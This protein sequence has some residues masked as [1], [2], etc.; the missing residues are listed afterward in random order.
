[1]INPEANRLPVIIT[2]ST[3]CVCLGVV[4]Y[5]VPRPAVIVALAFVPLAG[6]FVLNKTFWLVLLFVVFSFF[7]IHEA[8]PQLYSLKI[9]LMLSI[10]A[11][12]ALLWHA[13]ISKELKIFWH[14]CLN[15]LAIFWVLVFI[16][17]T[18]ASNRPIA[19]AEFKGV[20]WKIIVMTLAIVWLVNSAEYLV[21]TSTAI[22][23]AGS[24]VAGIAINNSIHGIGLVEG[25]R[26]TI[27]R[28]FGSMLGD[29]NDL[30]LVLM[31]PLAFA[32]SQVVTTGIP[33]SKRIISVGVT[34]LLL[35]AVIATQSRGGLLGSLAV[36]GIFAF[37]VIRSKL[38][39]I[40]LG[41][42]GSIGLYFVAGIS[43]R[44]S[45]GAAEQGVDES[46]MGRIYAWEAAFKMA[47]DNPLTGVGLDNF[48]S[49]YFFYSSHW[50]GLNHAVHS[51]WFGVLA[52]TG[53]LGL[54]IFLILITSLIKTI[55]ST[56]KQLSETTNTVDPNLNAAAYAVY[57]GLI[58]TI[59]SG[60]FLTQGFNWPI[61]IL[62]A[63]VVAIANISQTACQKEKI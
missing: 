3:L 35:A 4:W 51:T 41:A 53:F 47:L 11:L 27:G 22:I 45:G 24:L 16:G 34:V 48:F 54:T 30:S 2:I 32:I 29:P 42:I 59:V 31:F 14:P 55:R 43:D 39:L 10:S 36:I 44:A 18:F 63:L 37:K 28:D 21:K 38:L 8:I 25:S 26:V 57:A 9:P 60:T 5:F 1:M 62:S 61:Y 7:R 46:A 33:L 49:N 52:E 17:I 58:G 6:L 56:L 50:D 40:T 23:C 12:S 19:L 20:Y 13:F 15:W